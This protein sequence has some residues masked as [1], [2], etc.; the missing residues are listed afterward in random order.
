MISSPTILLT[1]ATGFIGRK[2]LE[3]LLKGNYRV[4]CLVRENTRIPANSEVNITIQEIEKL[5]SSTKIDFV[6]HLATYFCGDE[7][8]DDEDL[9][10]L[11]DSNIRFTSEL[12]SKLSLI[13]PQLVLY[14]ESTSQYLDRA[15]FPNVYSM[16]K[17]I[18]SNFLEY[19]LPAETKLVK[20]VFP[21]TYGVHD[22]RPKLFSYLVN[23][24]ENKVELQ[25][26]E[27]NQILNYLYVD[28]VVDG[29][30]FA[31]EKSNFD[32]QVSLFRLRSEESHT[33]KEIIHKFEKV[34]NKKLNVV[35]GLKP[36]KA[37]DVFDISEFP[38]DLPEWKSK[39][40]LEEGI[41]K[42][43]DS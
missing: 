33:L 34:T 41:Q 5:T 16:T 32:K 9:K 27:G 11:I 1:G 18:G 4:I 17:S 29:I 19:F 23:C 38:E 26:S 3:A 36:Y 6:I 21:D 24:L 25:L 2:L 15:S 10:K 35:W 30:V 42:I 7:F 31:I 43:L 13:R 14:S 8:P 37:T 40:S 12:A 39:I 20:L 22:P 28:D